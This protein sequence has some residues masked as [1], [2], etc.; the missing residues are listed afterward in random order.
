MDID[1]RVGKLIQIA[2]DFERFD[3]L[4]RFDKELKEKNMATTQ[5]PVCGLKK[6]SSSTSLQG[7]Q[8]H[9]SYGL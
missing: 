5:E 1:V 9:Y 8:L 4:S 7:E 3:S 2:E 6:I